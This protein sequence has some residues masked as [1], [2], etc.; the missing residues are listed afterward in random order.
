VALEATLVK[1]TFTGLVTELFATGDRKRL[2]AVLEEWLSGV[3]QRIA[4]YATN[5]SVSSTPY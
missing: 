1:A 4:A 3:D 2:T 5:G